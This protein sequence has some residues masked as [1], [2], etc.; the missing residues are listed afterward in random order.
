[1]LANGQPRLLGMPSMV[2]SCSIGDSDIEGIF[3]LPVGTASAEGPD[4]IL[5]PSAVE[6]GSLGRPGLRRWNAQVAKRIDFAA[7]CDE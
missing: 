6:A 2:K 7:S 1:M 5:T 3:W 4:Q